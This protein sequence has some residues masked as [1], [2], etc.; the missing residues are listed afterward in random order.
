MLK[1]SLMFF[2]FVVIMMIPPVVNG[3]TDELVYFDLEENPEIVKEKVSKAFW[4]NPLNTP[5]ML[6]LLGIAAVSIFI[7][8][9]KKWHI[10]E[11]TSDMRD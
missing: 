6:A 4:E 11:K 3:A 2:L 8:W 1:P 9:R 10:H 5:P 7:A